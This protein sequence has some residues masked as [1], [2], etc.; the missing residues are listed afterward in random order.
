MKV[1]I[2]DF[3][4]TIIPFDSGSHFCVWSFFHYPWIIVFAPYAA[5]GL[6]RYGLIGRNVAKMKNY[7]FRFIGAIPLEKAVSKFWNR[8]EK[9]VFVWYKNRSREN[10]L[11]VISASP[12]FLLQDIAKRLEFDTL[13]C[14]RHNRKTGAIIGENC[15]SEEKVR[16]FRELFPDAEVREVRSDS[17]RHD[18]YIFSLGERCF[19]VEKD[20]SL[21]EFDY[22]EKYKE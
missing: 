9:K 7:A 19:H 12:D 8:Y 16:R 4:K 11:V 15:R 14:T 17:Y 3:D 13:I 1:D 2:Y 10:K 20:G 18:K 21:T 6:I 22:A 5:Y